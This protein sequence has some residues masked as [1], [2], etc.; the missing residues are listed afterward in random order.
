MDWPRKDG[1]T[2]GT[3]DHRLGCRLRQADRERA[4]R[5]R[6]R[7]T[8]SASAPRSTCRPYVF[9]DRDRTRAVPTV[10]KTWVRKGPAGADFEAAHVLPTLVRK[11]IRSSKER[12]GGQAGKPLF[13]YMPLTAPHTPIV[14]TPEWQ[15]K[16]GLNPY[17]DFVMQVDRAVG[18]VLGSLEKQGLAGNTLVIFTSDNGCSPAGE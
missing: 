3:I 15:G 6:L 11:A 18:Q 8:T 12:R 17:G 5:R 9:I 14:P 2:S 4:E 1:E 10:E 7:S 13:L 16:S